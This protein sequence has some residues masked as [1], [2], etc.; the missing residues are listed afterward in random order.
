MLCT[1]ELGYMYADIL[2]KGLS[3]K[4][5]IVIGCDFIIII[6]II[7]IIIKSHN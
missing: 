7:I 6:I 1:A 2:C 4:V 5:S 3:P